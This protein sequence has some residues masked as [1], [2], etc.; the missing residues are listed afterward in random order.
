MTKAPL[1]SEAAMVLGLAGSALPF[2][3]SRTEEAERWLRVLRLHGSVSAPLQSLGIGE[4]PVAAPEPA[5]GAGQATAAQ[6]ARQHSED[7]E[8]VIEVVTALALERARRRGAPVAQTTDILVGAIEHYRQDFDRV[9]EAFGTDRAEV[10]A[11]VS[12]HERS[13]A[14]AEERGSA[15]G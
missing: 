8:R 14:C 1:S 5:P 3:A 4:R 12:A 15:T 11:S 2:A 9:L 7:P 13:G 6:S 10:L